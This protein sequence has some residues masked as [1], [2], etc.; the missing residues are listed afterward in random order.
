MDSLSNLDNKTK[1]SKSAIMYERKQ[2]QV[3]EPGKLGD[4]KE[5]DITIRRRIKRTRQEMYVYG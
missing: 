2:K 3:E 4:A 1:E 5:K